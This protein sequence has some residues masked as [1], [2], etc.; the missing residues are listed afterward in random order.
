[1]RKEGQRQRD[2]ISFQRDIILHSPPDTRAPILP[3]GVTPL[4]KKKSVTPLQDLPKKGKAR[5]IMGQIKP[6]HAGEKM[7]HIKNQCGVLISDTFIFLQRDTILHF[8]AGYRRP[9]SPSRLTPARKASAVRPMSV[10]ML[11]SGYSG[12]IS[13][14]A[15]TS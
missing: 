7:C 4:W 1:M 12:Y 10:S 14:N 15:S 2:I 9:H 11:P 5:V 6:T 8:T 3:R 13:T